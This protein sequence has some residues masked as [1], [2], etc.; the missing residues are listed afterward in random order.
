MGFGSHRGLHCVRK[1]SSLTEPNID[2]LTLS[3]QDL[4]NEAQASSGS[5][6]TT[7]TSDSS[8][9]LAWSTSWSWEGA[10][11]QVKSYAN[12]VVSK[13]PGTLWRAQLCPQIQLLTFDGQPCPA[14]RRYPPLAQFLPLGSGGKNQ[15]HL[16]VILDA[17]P[18]FLPQLLR[19][20]HRSRRF[21]RYVYLLNLN[22][23]QRIRVSNK[24]LC[25][26]S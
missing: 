24:T 7:V 13:Y 2:Y 18:L 16:L 5:Q 9:S 22:G 23:L 15:T 20:Q 1:S 14:S 19:K 25:S 8:N 21:V 4:W 26:L 11:N 10:S 12:A 17:D 3:Y 6:C